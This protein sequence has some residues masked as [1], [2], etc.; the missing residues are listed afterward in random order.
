MCG[1][2]RVRLHKLRVEDGKVG[3]DSVGSQWDGGGRGS[4]GGAA[5]TGVGDL[6]V[7]SHL[8]ITG[9]C[10]RDSMNECSYKNKERKI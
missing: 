5:G 4:A 7:V 3:G 2:N 9:G 1:R 8:A 6:V 10:G